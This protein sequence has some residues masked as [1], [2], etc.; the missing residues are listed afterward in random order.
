MPDPHI[1]GLSVSSET[2]QVLLA[3]HDG[4]FDVSKKPAVKIGPTNDL[5]GFTA[6]MAGA[7]RARYG[8]PAR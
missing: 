7:L 4:L 2:G 8:R 3:T 6:A 1:H 5:M